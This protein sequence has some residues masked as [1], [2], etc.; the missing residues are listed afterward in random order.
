[1]PEGKLVLM[2]GRKEKKKALKKFGKSLILLKL[3]KLL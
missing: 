3:V 1:M 2:N